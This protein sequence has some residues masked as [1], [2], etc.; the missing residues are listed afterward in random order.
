MDK[1]ETLFRTILAGIILMVLSFLLYIT[2][3]Y[4]AFIILF[5]LGAILLLAGYILQARY[6]DD[7]QK[8]LDDL[9]QSK[10][11]LE[12][13]IESLDGPYIP[14]EDCA[15]IIDLESLR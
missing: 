4:T 10:D 7:T 1:V 12:G 2:Y 13:T 9:M 3:P 5:I 11:D 6:R 15:E 8:T 14:Y